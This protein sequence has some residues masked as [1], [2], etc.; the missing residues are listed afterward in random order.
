MLI[1]AYNENESVVITCKAILFDL[2]G[3]LVDSGECVQ[4]TWR[5]WALAH[6]L[7][8]E[9]VVEA[10]HGRRAIETVRLVAPDLKAD[11]E[12]ARL[13]AS[14]STTSEGVYEIAG[15]RSLIESLPDEA[16][17]IVTSGIRDVA[18]FR[19]RLVGIPIPPVMVCGDEIT[20][21]KPDPEGYLQAAKRLGR[22]AEDCLVIEDAPAGIEAARGARM[23]VIAVAGTYPPEQL[24][25]AD[26]VV[27]K[28]GDLAVRHAG[29]E[30]YVTTTAEGVP[31]LNFSR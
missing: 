2:D 12:L 27:A 22:A 14:E 6:H 29:D 1:A 20:R 16:W 24:T 4:R 5:K 18:E 30:L 11:D 3:V 25:S 7:D 26:A 21:G 28:L 10:A 13:A 19:L 15:A 17:A 23:R 31:S 9:R 8:P